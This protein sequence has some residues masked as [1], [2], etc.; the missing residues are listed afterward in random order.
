[1]FV[2]EADGTVPFMTTICDD[3]GVPVYSGSGSLPVSLTHKLSLDAVHEYRKSG[4]ATIVLML[5]DLDLMG[6]R[7]IFVPAARDIEQFASDYG[8]HKAVIVLRIGVTPDQVLHLPAHLRQ[9]GVPMISQGRNKPKIPA[10]WWPRDHNGDQ[11]ILP[12]S[13]ALLDIL[14]G[15]L[16]QHLEALLNDPAQRQA[17]IDTE[18]Q[19]R[20]DA[21]IAL[22]A[23]L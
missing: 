19:L 17:M 10:P 13:E 2:T 5:T 8:D 7:N 22:S 14:P 21:A 16:R 11:W 6:L 15:I 18:V 3:F 20:T 1:M 4:T 9:P 23:L 12:T